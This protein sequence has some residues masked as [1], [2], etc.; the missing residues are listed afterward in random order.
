MG[1]IDKRASHK[2]TLRPNT[3]AS[4]IMRPSSRNGPAPTLP[5][6]VTRGN[7]SVVPSSGSRIGGSRNM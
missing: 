5:P 4:S 2:P 7:S 1:S 3:A 6:P